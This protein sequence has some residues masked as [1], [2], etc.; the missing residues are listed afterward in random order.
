MN[1]IPPSCFPHVFCQTDVI[2]VRFFWLPSSEPVIVFY[3]R[4]TICR[5]AKIKIKKSP[6]VA[7]AKPLLLTRSVHKEKNVHLNAYK[8]CHMNLASYSYSST[9]EA[10]T[11]SLIL[12]S[13]HPFINPSFIFP[14][15]ISLLNSVQQRE[16]RDRGEEA[17]LMLHCVC[18]HL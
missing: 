5:K 14:P 6:V 12:P 17:N 11:H 7:P 13:P 3:R 15:F 10:V 9:V 18:M 2:L 16:T 1:N 8:N 4:N